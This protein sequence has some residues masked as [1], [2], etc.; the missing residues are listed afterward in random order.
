MHGAPASAAVPTTGPAR[1]PVT[2][3]AC[4]LHLPLP[5]PP[6]RRRG[7][8]DA[9]RERLQQAASGA[10]EAD[11]L[12]AL[13]EVEAE[14]EKLLRALDA[15]EEKQAWDRL[16]PLQSTLDFAALAVSKAE[17][18]LAPPPLTGQGAADAAAK[19]GP[20]TAMEQAAM[21]EMAEDMVNALVDDESDEEDEDGLLQ[22]MAARHK[23]KGK[24][25]KK[26]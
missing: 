17:A 1:A 18:L 10:G 21:E 12:V 11:R 6:V 23:A 13:T 19:P 25:K 15:A 8:L 2:R 5:A 14:R 3:P 7:R 22:M 20:S 4:P 16:Q 9:L 24:G 26:G